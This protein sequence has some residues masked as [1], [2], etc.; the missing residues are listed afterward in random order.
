VHGEL[1]AAGQGNGRQCGKAAGSP[2]ESDQES[3][4]RGIRGRRAA[5]G[6]VHAVDGGE[7]LRIIF[8]HR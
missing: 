6:G 4:R 7:I 2:D 5:V 1:K 8:V 3:A